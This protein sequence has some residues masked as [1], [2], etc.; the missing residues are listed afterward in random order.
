MKNVLKDIIKE[1]MDAKNFLILAHHNADI[2]AVSSMLALKEAFKEKMRFPDI[3]VAESVSRA[4]QDIVGDEKI[5]INP[6][7]EGYDAVLVLDTPSQEQL[8]PIKVN[9]IH[10]RLLL[11]D[12]HSPGNLERFADMAYIDPDAKSTSEIIYEMIKEMGCEITEKIATYIITGIVADT[13]H[14]KLADEKTF[15]L[16][17]ELLP[18][19]GKDYYEIL[20][21]LY[22][23]VDIS[24]RIAIVKAASRM[25]A[26]RLGDVIIVFS[27]VGSFEASAARSLLR[28]GADIAVVANLDKKSIRISGRARRHLSERIHLAD[29]IFSKIE[30]LIGGSAGGHDSAASANGTR[31]ENL[32]KVF[33][34][35]LLLFEEKLGEKPEKL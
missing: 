31:P 32:D 28:L 27:T 26:Y 14:L 21:L 5:L 35:M 15:L 2:D 1:L 17:A 25:N 34:K 20:E 11:I 7:P 8:E 12:H 10:G 33:E 29:D 24:E 13:S 30:K 3:G 22:T 16:M 9:E 4:A 6:S 18:K 19:T 23:D